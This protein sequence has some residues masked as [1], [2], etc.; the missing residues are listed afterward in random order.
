MRAPAGTHTLIT[1][2][3]KGNACASEGVEIAAA[4]SSDGGGGGGGGGVDR[5]HDG[6]AERNLRISCTHCAESER[7]S[8]RRCRAANTGEGGH[9][10]ARSDGGTF[11][12]HLLAP[13]TVRQRV[14]TAADADAVSTRRQQ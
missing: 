8:A 9:M 3:P 4:N 13:L 5:Q 6:G 7:D 11:V 12:R 14:G 1:T 10:G 2:R